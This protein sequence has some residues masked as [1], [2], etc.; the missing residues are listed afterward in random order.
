MKPYVLAFFSILTL[1]VASAQSYEVDWGPEYRRSG[2]IYSNFFLAGLTDDAYHMLLYSRKESTLFSYDW[3]HKVV[4][5]KSVAFATGR[6]ELILRRF[7]RTRNSNFAVLN[8]YDRR[9]KEV[10]TFVSR[11]QHQDFGEL[12]PIATQD[13]R[14]NRAR[15]AVAAMESL[16]AENSPLTTSLDGTVVLFTQTNLNRQRNAPEHV[17][18][19]VFDADFRPLWT[20]EYTIPQSGNSTQLLSS[21]I[22]NS[23]EVYLLV[24]AWKDFSERRQDTGLPPYRYELFK[25]TAQGEPQKIEI[26][27]GDQ[28]APQY[29]GLYVSEDRHAPVIIAGLYTDTERRSNLKGAFTLEV[30]DL[31]TSGEVTTQEFTSTFLDDLISNRANKRDRGLDNEYQIKSFVRFAD[32]TLG[33]IAEETYSVTTYDTTGPQMTTRTRTIY[34][35]NQLVIVLFGSDGQVVNMQKIDKTFDTTSPAVTSFA[36]AVVDDQLFLVYNDEKTRQ[37]RREIT[38][39]G[40]HRALFTDLTI[41]DNSGTVVHQEPLFTSDATDRKL[42]VPRQS[43]FNANYMVFLARSAKFFQC[44]IMRFR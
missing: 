42:F 15:N 37:E 11:F 36:T 43:D 44:G 5:T 2:G 24:R 21:A 9:A 35:T 18:L 38:G 16:Q 12:Q 6:D 13:V 32:G 10:R 27:L 30:D 25:L 1:A 33:F 14:A 7:I 31:F 34:H 40:S 41:I 28:L 20:K 4:D 3:N 29:A 19:N 17:Q 26:D 23:G 22:S 39:K 8:Q